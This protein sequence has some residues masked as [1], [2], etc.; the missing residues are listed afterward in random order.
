[1]KSISVEAIFNLTFYANKNGHGTIMEG[2][3]E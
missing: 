3:L 1:M 2:N